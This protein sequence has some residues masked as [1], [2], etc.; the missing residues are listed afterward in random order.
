MCGCTGAK[1][2]PA[3]LLSAANPSPEALT[4]PYT[5]RFLIWPRP[6]LVISQWDAVIRHVADGMGYDW[7]FISAVARSESEFNPKAVSHAGAVGLMQVMPVSARG[8]GVSR[9][10]LFDPVVNVETGVG[11][12]D[13]IVATLHFPDWISARDRCSITIAAYN[14]GIGHVLD[15]RR[16][17]VKYGENYNSWDVVAKYLV[18]KSD[19]VFYE[20]E[21]VSHSGVFN[22]SG[23][24]LGYVAKVMRFYDN[25]C[26]IA[27]P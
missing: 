6:H 11:V 15:A 14:S 12:L 7:R 23:E 13:R 5:G 17:A 21:E 2:D 3:P 10:Q 18:L 8:F 22:G 27:E 4:N 20:D 1:N 26:E 25:Y 16:L 24:T 19:P 9:E